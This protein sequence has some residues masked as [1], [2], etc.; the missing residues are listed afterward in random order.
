MVRRSHSLPPGASTAPRAALVLPVYFSFTFTTGEE[1][2]FW[3]LATALAHP[4]R[5]SEG[6]G[7]AP[8]RTLD[9]ARLATGT[10]Q[11][12]PSALAP[13]DAPAYEPP[14]PTSAVAVALKR[15]LTPTQGVVP[16][17]RG[18]LYGAAQAG[19]RQ[20]DLVDPPGSSPGAAFEHQ[21][22][23]W[24]TLNIDPALRVAAAL[25]TLTV[26]H[27]RDALLES[28]WRQVAQTSEVNTLLSRAQ[29]ARAVS[30]RQAVRHLSG[31]SPPELVRHVSPQ[32]SR[33]PVTAADRA[34]RAVAGS[35]HSVIADIAES[36]A[37][38]AVV[39]PT[40]R[41]L[42]RPRGPHARR[43]PAPAAPT[44]PSEIADAVRQRLD[45][46]HTV[47]ARIHAEW[48]SPPA[49]AALSADG[50]DPLRHLAPEVSYPAGVAR[51]LVDV[52]PDAIL[53]GIER[54]PPNTVVALKTV[55]W[56]IAAYLAG[57]NSEITRLLAWSG[58]PGDRRATPFRQFWDTADVDA[59]TAISDW[60]H[61]A[62]LSEVLSGGSAGNLVVAVRG[63]LLRRYPTTAV[64]LVPAI[65]DQAAPS[66]HRFEMPSDAHQIHTPLFT[67]TFPP[68]VRC[69]GFD[70]SPAGAL[71][72]PG[73][74]FVLQQQ[75]TEA[76]FSSDG[77]T[78]TTKPE[79][80]SHYPISSVAPGQLNGAGVARVAHQQQGLVAIHLN[81]LLPANS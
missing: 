19:I 55:P 21:P 65:A 60:P 53:S 46:A 30:Q 18:P 8:A 61:D 39:T 70:L 22:Q 2:D 3:T 25:G 38:P 81:A 33:L 78:G 73:Y 40:Y 72:P 9:T 14:A 41:R 20:A 48:V 67:A 12:L 79:H 1:G 63:E 11:P 6:D 77:F 24:R 50:R 26:E 49:A 17:L 10:S 37:L 32:A 54:I 35:L 64:Y 52:A 66:G 69:F 43:T 75:A 45:P 59:I 58:V 80:A 15:W 4:P 71:Q 68:D 42:S 23:W 47:P 13:L 16:E 31:A 51:S 36:P 7:A 27:E 57:L 62:Q 34:G 5:L 56:F 74:F 44:V 28:A 76:S 29:L